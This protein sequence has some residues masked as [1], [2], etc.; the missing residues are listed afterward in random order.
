MG[1]KRKSVN[2]LQEHIEEFYN[3]GNPKECDTAN[4]LRFDAVLP[5]KEKFNI[6]ITQ[7]PT[8]DSSGLAS[9][10]AVHPWKPIGGGGK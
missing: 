7:L 5:P 8:L 1:D 3:I 10:D 9:R 2:P 6:E 4:D